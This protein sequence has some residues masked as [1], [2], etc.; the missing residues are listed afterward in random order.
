MAKIKR[1]RLATILSLALSAA[2]T[3]IRADE[4]NAWE[5]WHALLQKACPENHVDW[6]CDTCWT[7]LTGAFEDTLS[8]AGRNKVTKNLSFQGCEKEQIGLSCEM[9][10]FLTA[11]EKAGFLPRFVRFGCRVVKC[12]EVAL[13]SR[14][15]DHAP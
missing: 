9:S 8:E 12:E 14:F 6:A 15:P 5:Q 11:F 7:Q 2:P 4:A 13:C 3:P 1:V 10:A